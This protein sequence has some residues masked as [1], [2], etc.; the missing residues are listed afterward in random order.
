MPVTIEGVSDGRRGVHRNTSI[1]SKINWLQNALA[2]QNLHVGLFN[3]AQ[4]QCLF[5][6]N[7]LA[8]CF[9]FDPAG[10][11]LV[12]STGPPSDISITTSLSRLLMAIFATEPPLEGE[13]MPA[14]RPPADR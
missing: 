2:D 12:D 6:S 4:L 5:D 9:M 3:V 1:A 10:A 11:F 13:D 14:A 8:R 7:H